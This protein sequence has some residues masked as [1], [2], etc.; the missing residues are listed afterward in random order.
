MTAGPNVNFLPEE[1]QVSFG[2][3]DTNLS[4]FQIFCAQ[5][6]DS[7]GLVFFCMSTYQSLDLIPK[8]LIEGEMF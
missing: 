7:S 5:A 3:E 8:E 1:N 2:T 6:L 4:I